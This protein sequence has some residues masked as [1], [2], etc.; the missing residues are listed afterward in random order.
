[1]QTFAGIASEG[2]NGDGTALLQA[3]LPPGSHCEKSPLA[4]LGAEPGA[5]VSLGDSGHRVIALFSG[6]LENAGELR[7]RL[8][9]DGHQM[10]GGAPAEIIVHLYEKHGSDVFGLLKGSFAAAVYDGGKHRLLLGRD[11]IGIEPLY[12]FI[13][14]GVLV[15][16]NRLPVLARH[17]LVPTDLDVNAVSVF[18][19]LQYIPDPDTIYRNVRKLPPGHLLEA[20]LESANT[21]I[22]SFR[23][24]D[25]AAKR[26]D[27]SFADAC[28]ELR[29][30]VENAVAAELE[31]SGGNTGV[32]LS[33]G[34]D[35]A[36]LAA[37]SARHSG[38]KPVNVFTVGYD[39][40]AYDERALAKSTLDFINARS[41]NVLKHHVRKLEVPPLELAEELAAFHGE[42]Y[43]DVSVLPTHLLCKFASGQTG[44]ALGGDGGDEFFAG[45]ERYSAMRIA[46]FFELLPL[47]LR[48]GVFSLL[49]GAVPDAG[50]RS[51]CGRARRMCNLIAAPSHRAYFNLLDRAPAD[52]KKALF[53]P[54]LGE[55]LWNDTAEIFGR[56]EWEI[57]A[58]DPAEGYS[59]LD[60]HTYLPG[61][62][63]AKLEIAAGYAKMEVVTPYLN[64]AVTEFAAKLPFEYK[65]LGKNR[66]RILKAAFADLLPPDTAKR[67][68]RGFGSPMAAWLRRE[69]RPGAESALF[70]SPLC[71]DGYIVPEA[72]RKLWLRHQSGKADHS[73]LLWSLINLAWFLKRR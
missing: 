63:C 15:F 29:E 58:A 51:L 25:F 27:L 23:K 12:Y 52:T 65:M 3:M 14:R 10:Q 47:S 20:R 11:V 60:I 44:A 48:R 21:S 72:L 67:R 68:K 16:S 31:R 54:E 33:G 35:S 55:A 61:D 50:E 53:G 5:A 28:A 41:G 43:A 57:T 71:R 62:G 69:W 70:D 38:G 6:R 32:F 66:K 9:A 46:G 45:Y 17:P 64:S 36:V 59:E 18:L 40:P 2:L 22:R 8:A 13:H 37:L 42:P 1:M 56:R 19:S 39:D 73:Y 49:A 24:I 4:V 7:R 30:R 26:R 34:V